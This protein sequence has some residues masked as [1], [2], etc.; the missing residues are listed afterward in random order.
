MKINLI[1]VDPFTVE[2]AVL[3][4]IRDC[5]SEG[6]SHSRI[7]LILINGSKKFTGKVSF[8]CRYYDEDGVFCGVDT[9]WSNLDRSIAPSKSIDV[10]L[11]VNPPKNASRVD[12]RA[13]CKTNLMDLEITDLPSMVYFIS[14]ITFGI[15]LVIGKF[16]K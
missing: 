6:G 11:A 3:R 14:L 1:E 5:E 13:S 10:I 4:Q 9:P 16:F 7:D 2:E 8:T 15:G 12:V